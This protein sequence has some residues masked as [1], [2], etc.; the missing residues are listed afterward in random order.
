M[1]CVVS[2]VKER[3]DANVALFQ[4]ELKVIAAAHRKDMEREEIARKLQVMEIGWQQL[5]LK[6]LR[7][8]VH[9]GRWSRPF[10]IDPDYQ[11][12][13]EIVAQ[14]HCQPESNSAAS[15]SG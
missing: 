11:E 6:R 13:A 3:H 10:Y 8:S 4:K 14:D 7:E 12:A 5:D 1:T 2:E 15:R 9:S